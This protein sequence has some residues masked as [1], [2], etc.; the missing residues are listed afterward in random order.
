MSCWNVLIIIKK[1]SYGN[2][3]MTMLMFPNGQIKLIFDRRKSESFHNISLFIRLIVEVFERLVPLS[4]IIKE[5]RSVPLP[6][7][8]LLPRNRQ[9]TLNFEL[10]QIQPNDDNRPF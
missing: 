6:R 4:F 7:S 8:N 3:D 5:G 2:A 9:L 10:A 1:E